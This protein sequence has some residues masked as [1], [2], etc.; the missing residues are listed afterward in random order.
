MVNHIVFPSVAS[1]GVYLDT[2]MFD[3]KKY[4]RSATKRGFLSFWCVC[5]CEPSEEM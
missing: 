2:F 4:R 3:P 5:V 1:F